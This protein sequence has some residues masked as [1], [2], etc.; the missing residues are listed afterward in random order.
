MKQLSKNILLLLIGG[1][2]FS[3]CADEVDN[4]G[5]NDQHVV[6]G[7]PVE[8]SLY[9]KSDKSTV[10]T[11][12]NSE[13]GSA[14]KDLYVVLFNTDQA[15]SYAGS[16]YFT[17]EEE[18]LPSLADNDGRVKMKTTSGKKK[19]YAVANVRSANFSSSEETEDLYSRIK[20]FC[21]E[22]DASK[23]TL[24]KWLEISAMMTDEFT[25]W[26]DDLFLMSGKYAAEPSLGL[27]AGECI[28]NIDGT[29][30]DGVIEL[31]RAVASITFNISGEGFT[32]ES[33][34]VMQLPRG[35]QLF[36]DNGTTGVPEDNTFDYPNANTSFKQ[37]SFTFYMLENQNDPVTDYP[38]D[39]QEQ[40]KWREK[41]EV[42]PATSTYLK[43]KGSY[44]GKA[45]YPFDGKEEQK[46]ASASVTYYIH[47]GYVPDAGSFSIKRNH[48]YI[49]NVVVNGVEDIIVEATTDEDNPRSDGEV[50]F[51][52]KDYIELDAHYG[53]VFLTFQSGEELGAYEFVSKVKTVS[54]NWIEKS[55]NIANPI[56][57]N[58]VYFVDEADVLALEGNKK[59]PNFKNLEAEDNPQIMTINELANEFKKDKGEGVEGRYYKQG[60][61]VYAYISENYYDDYSLS[62]FVSYSPSGAMDKAR[63][64]S[65]A[66]RQATEDGKTS[67]VSTARYVL[68]QKPIVTFYNVPSVTNPWGV[69]WVNENL[70]SDYNSLGDNVG[71][72]GKASA[73][74]EY[75]LKKDLRESSEMKYG[76]TAMKHELTQSGLMADE[77]AWFNKDIIGTKVEKTGG[78]KDWDLYY[79]KAY[80]ACMSRNRDEDGDGEIDND[81]IKWYLPA[82]DQYQHLWIGMNAL[83]NAAKLYPQEFQQRIW[84]FYHYAS[85]GGHVYWA[86]EGNAVSFNLGEYSGPTLGYGKFHVRCA[87]NLKSDTYDDIAKKDLTKISLGKY[88]GSGHD[89]GSYVTLNVGET[90]T[91]ESLRSGYM[92]NGM[93]GMHNEYDEANRI[94]S[95]VIDVATLT[96][97]PR[98]NIVNG[99]FPS[100]HFWTDGDGYGGGLNWADMAT[101]FRPVSHEG[102]GRNPCE[103][104][105]GSGT[106]W[107]PA[108]QNEIILITSIL[109]ADDDSNTGFKKA[110]QA[111]TYYSFWDIENDKAAVKNPHSGERRGFGYGGEY[112]TLSPGKWHL[113]CV[114]DARK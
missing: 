45:T 15:G 58:W 32:P 64:M 54:T 27:N 108:N 70:P 56:D 76:L 44:S 39:A 55:V 9:Y 101:I 88:N 51:A 30:S 97:T 66:I 28:F 52:E 41:K 78:Y 111:Q 59:N 3:A 37:N 23:K 105:Y 4:V 7:I 17:G 26:P 110:I 106:G 25:Y 20:A 35:V 8:A 62:S 2:I 82:I 96:I 50:V 60:A 24:A 38:A 79:A 86:E 72:G 16:Q 80:A 18:L 112:M 77:A 49:Y 33:W 13:T 93:H 5:G 94:Y 14:V 109:G 83:P 71:E 84:D 69:E 11:R 89:L 90:L 114:R 74:L 21:D 6:D 85:S 29:V 107:R 31:D 102:K 104:Y 92:I 73:G 57:I 1:F 47:L 48:K 67:V 99:N 10:I 46:D 98:V 61:R 34:Q 63:T 42:A 87:R 81:E 75:G 22:T 113:R 19:V 91:N 53:R 12:A 40:A 103:E 36:S 68:R 95:G 65:I 100:T 43:L